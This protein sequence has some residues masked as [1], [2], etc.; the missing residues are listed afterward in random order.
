MITVEELI[1]TLD[2]DATEADLK[3]A[4]E[5]LLEA[6]S[7]WPTSISEPSELV[8]E[9]KLHINSKLTFKNIERFLKT[10][11]VE[12]D[13]WKMESLSSILNIFKIER[14]EIVDGELEL[15]VLLQRI[16]NRLKI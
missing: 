5:S 14:N 15:E 6:I 13:A 10:Q 1:D 11:R 4:A 16:T 7:D 3:S 12:K 8:T 2:N 9:L